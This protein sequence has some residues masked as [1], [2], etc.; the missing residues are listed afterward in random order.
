M[1]GASQMKFEAAVNRII[2]ETNTA[3]KFIKFTSLID[4]INSNIYIN[5][6]QSDSHIAK[7]AD[8]ITSIL[9]HHS[10]QHR[11]HILETINDS[12]VRA[13]EMEWEVEEKNWKK[14]KKAVEA[15]LAFKLANLKGFE[16][17]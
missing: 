5:H 6:I 11:K 1:T 9:M 7:I 10:E 16:N 12:I 2:S 17:I 8:D 14:L 13:H 15:Q 3:D 4:F